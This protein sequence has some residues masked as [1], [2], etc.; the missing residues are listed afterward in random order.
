MIQTASPSKSQHRRSYSRETSV[1]RKLVGHELLYHHLHE[2]S[3][4]VE[5]QFHIDNEELHLEISQERQRS[6]SRGKKDFH[7]PVVGDFY[8]K[9][10]QIEKK[11]EQRYEMLQRSG[12]GF[13]KHDH[14]FSSSH[15]KHSHHHHHH[16]HHD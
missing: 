4:Q 3:Y 7:F 8:E 9:K 2:R 15:K 11:M 16:H 14:S 5:P 10:K 12:S 13:H 6:K 1:P